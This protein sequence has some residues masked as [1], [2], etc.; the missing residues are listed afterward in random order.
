MNSYSQHLATAVEEIRAFADSDEGKAC[1]PRFYQQMIELTES[2]KSARSDEEA[3][4]FLDMLLWCVVES[5]PPKKNFAPS[6]DIAAAAMQ[7]KRK[8]E[9]KRRRLARENQ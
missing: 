9:F 3:E 8:A 1:E 5:V 4:R 6:I 7:R 2:V